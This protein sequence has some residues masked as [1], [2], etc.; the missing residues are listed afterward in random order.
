[1]SSVE[2]LRE[3]VSERLTAAAE[4]IFRVF[5]KTI[6]EYEEEL[7]RQRRL[8]DLVQN[9]LYRTELPQQHVCK[10][11]EVP[12][13]QQ[14][15][16][17]GRSSSLD[18]EEPEPPQIK[19]EQEE[20]CS[21]QQ[22]E[23]LLLKQEEDDFMLT[24]VHEESEHSED[25]T[26]YFNPADAGSAAETEFVDNIPVITYVIPEANSDH[27]LLSDSSH[28]AE[29]QNQK[30]GNHRD[31]GSTRDPELHTKNVYSSTMSNVRC[32]THTGEKSLIC[33]ICGRAFKFKSQLFIHYRIHTG[34]KPFSCKTCGKD[35]QY[36]SGLLAHMRVHTGEKPYSCETCGKAFQY[37]G[38]L[39][40]HIRVHTGEKPYLCKTC[41]KRFSDKSALK[42]H[43][44]IHT[45]EKPYMCITCGR[46]FRC[47][48]HL[49]G[50]MKIHTREKL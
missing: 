46:D 2:Y 23:Q 25:Q 27:Q 5:K 3:F 15:C 7:E 11:E 43:V 18:Q 31:S 8:L 28:V 20:L 48:S 49:T 40:V 22:G 42:R 19:E 29:S 9:E 50:H 14:L 13:E 45:G 1:M 4:E 32:N 16:I 39:K 36:N 30:R 34:D 26:I 41:E 38:D 17:Q 35:F 47:K 10:E 12:A 21:S 44:R 24:P 37:N 33:D 6:V